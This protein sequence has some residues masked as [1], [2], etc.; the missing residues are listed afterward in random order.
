MCA[1]VQTHLENF[2]HRMTLSNKIFAWDYHTN[3]QLAL[4][5]C[6]SKAYTG[7]F[8]ILLSQ[9]YAFVQNPN[10]VYLQSNIVYHSVRDNLFLFHSEFVLFSIGFFVYFHITNWVNQMSQIRFLRNGIQS[11]ENYIT[12]ITR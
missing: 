1:Q 4:H 3:A 9:P 5:T 7:E 2:K 6:I 12:N 10:S 8:L 11:K